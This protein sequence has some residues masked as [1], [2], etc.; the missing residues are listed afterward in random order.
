MA[1]SQRMLLM[2]SVGKIETSYIHAFPYELFYELR[3]F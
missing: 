3:G 2:T 1:D